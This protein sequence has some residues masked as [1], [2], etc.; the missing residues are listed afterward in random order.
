MRCVLRYERWW[1]APSMCTSSVNASVAA[2]VQDGAGEFQVIETVIQAGMAGI[3]ELEVPA[4][5]VAKIMT[6]APLPKC[7]DSVVMVRRMAA[8]H[9]YALMIEAEMRMA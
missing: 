5:H 2:L 9:S 7:C 8:T 1:F 4:G 6:G 3:A